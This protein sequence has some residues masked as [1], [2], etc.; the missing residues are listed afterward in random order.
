MLH[1]KKLKLHTTEWLTHVVPV[2]LLYMEKKESI[3]YLKEQDTEEE[4]LITHSAYNRHH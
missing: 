3:I 2:R 4:T 1:N